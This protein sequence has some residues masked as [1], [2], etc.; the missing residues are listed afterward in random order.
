MLSAEDI[1][2]GCKT[3]KDVCEIEGEV[4]KP[5]CLEVLFSKIALFNPK[6]EEDVVA[7]FNM[8]DD[9]YQF[10]RDSDYEQEIEDDMKEEETM[11]LRWRSRENS[12]KNG[13]VTTH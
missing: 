7:V 6:E 4:Y 8:K 1:L 3:L 12:V 13:N 2:A 5:G 10:E 9:D 11:P